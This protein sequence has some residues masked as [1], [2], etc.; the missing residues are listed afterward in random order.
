MKSDF[1][2]LKNLIY[3]QHQF[4]DHINCNIYTMYTLLF[5]NK[6]REDQP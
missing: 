6:K 3:L 5:K 2:P 4:D 1:K